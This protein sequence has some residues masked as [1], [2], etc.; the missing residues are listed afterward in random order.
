MIRLRTSSS[1]RKY[2]LARRECDIRK[3]RPLNA[4]TNNEIGRT[5]TQAF[6]IGRAT[7]S[8]IG[9]SSLLRFWGLGR[10]CNE[11]LGKRELHMRWRLHA[12]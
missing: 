8:E 12:E 7:L 9:A 3:P 11:I 4:H 5:K 2:A 1:G 6:H 10:V